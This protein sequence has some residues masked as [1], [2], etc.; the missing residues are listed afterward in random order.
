M[1]ETIKKALMGV[2]EAIGI[3]IP[4]LPVDPGSL[5]E[6]ATTALQGVTESATGVIDTA[7]AAA[8]AIPELPI[9]E[10]RPR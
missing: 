2:T 9:G 7:T 1:W 8:E 5:G 6:S 10:V 3:E 4:E